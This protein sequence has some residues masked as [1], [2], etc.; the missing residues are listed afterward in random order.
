MAYAERGD[1]VRRERRSVCRC[2]LGIR[3]RGRMA[4]ACDVHLL[5][6]VLWKLIW[7]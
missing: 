3:M 5:G 6:K 1:N 7:A 2:R 4:L